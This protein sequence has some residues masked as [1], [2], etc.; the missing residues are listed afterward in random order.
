MGEGGCDSLERMDSIPP[1]DYWIFSMPHAEV[2]MDLSSIF[3]ANGSL[4]LDLGAG[5]GSFIIDY[6][7]KNPQACLFAIEKKISRVRKIASK[8][9]RLNLK[10]LR[11]VHCCWEQFLLR[12]CMPSSVDEI[13]ILFPDPWPKRRHHKRR[14]IKAPVVQ[15]IADVL[16]PNG[17]CRL[18][19]DNREYF[20]WSEKLFLLSGYFEEKPLSLPS[21]YPE[22]LFQK[23][24]KERGIICYQA[25]WR[26]KTTL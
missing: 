15:A 25:V 12:H 5:E 23:R 17:I 26:K 14:S 13:H 9:R 6:A 3:G 7:M 21:E 20:L 10:N 2:A 18:L 16:K 1:L 4:M 22:S 19:T 11:V 8:A 24:F